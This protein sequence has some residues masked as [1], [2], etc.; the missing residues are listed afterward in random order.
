MRKGASSSEHRRTEPSD[1][2]EEERIVGNKSD[3]D[4]NVGSLHQQ[5][6]VVAADVL[7]VHDEEV[8]MLPPRV[9]Y[10]PDVISRR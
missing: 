6:D 7:V 5:D 4:T 2:Y 8:T 3:N 1:R 10:C 9:D